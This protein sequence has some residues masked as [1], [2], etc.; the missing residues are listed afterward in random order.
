MATNDCSKYALS[1]TILSA[2]KFDPIFDP[3]NASKVIG[4]H[5][6]IISTADHGGSIPQWIIKKFAP[7]GLTEFMETFSE[8]AKTNTPS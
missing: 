6:T 5:T 1:T 8:H 3:S 4:T 7:K 2:F